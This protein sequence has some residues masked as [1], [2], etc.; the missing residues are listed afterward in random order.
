MS[1]KKINYSFEDMQNAILK[2]I[3][4]MRKTNWMPEIVLSVNR[5]GC[6]PGVYLSHY[7]E[8]PHKVID[9]QLRDSSVSPNL[10]V[11]KDSIINNNRILIIDDINDSGSTFN[12]IKKNIV[13]SDSEVH[14]A[15]L[16]NNSKSKV[17]VDYHGQIID[18]SIN[19]VWYVFP[20]E[21]W[22]E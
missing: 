4:Q 6:V 2:I 16:I 9:V 8:K 1:V 11:L 12:F 3:G 5:G 14:F 19:P 21:N 15:V 22:W 7:I 20:W 17:K 18:K 10:S 13:K